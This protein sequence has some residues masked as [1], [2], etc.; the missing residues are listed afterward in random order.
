MNRS[1]SLPLPS[2]S[3]PSGSVVPFSLPSRPSSRCG[4]RSRV[5]FSSSPFSSFLRSPLALLFFRSAEY[6]ES[7]PSIVQCVPLLLIS[8]TISHEFE[9]D[10]FF[11][12]PLQPQVFLSGQHLSGRFRS[13]SSCPLVSHFCVKTPVI[14][15][16]SHRPHLSLLSPIPLFPFPF[17][18]RVVCCPAEY[19][20]LLSLPLSIESSI[21]L[22]KEITNER[23]VG[24]KGE[25][26]G[27][28]GGC[29]R[30]FGPST[31]SRFLFLSL[32]SH[33]PCFSP[34]THT[35][36]ATLQP[37][38]TL[39]ERCVSFLLLIIVSTPHTSPSLLVLPL[40]GTGHHLQGCHRLGRWSTRFD[41]RHHRRP[42]SGQRGQDQGPLHRS[43]SHR[44]FPSVSRSSSRAAH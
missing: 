27:S 3:T 22:K 41:R 19:K 20:F 26:S 31:K 34:L 40:L 11:F 28:S 10:F 16:S 6:D 2:A 23:R 37:C 17:R 35:H 5:R 4:S 18:C 39:K 14:P 32:P 38:P 7:G 33:S 43:L 25:E 13:C 12:F 44:S 24:K 21:A 42:S 8:L 9:T 1:R 30:R 29:R 36:S 15:Q